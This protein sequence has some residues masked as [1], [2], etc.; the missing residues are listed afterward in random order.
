M[1]ALVFRGPWDIDVEDRP[2]PEPAPGEVLVE[3]VATGICGSDLHGYTGENGRRF[4]GQVMGHETVGRVAAI[5]AANGSGGSTGLAV[6]GLVTVEPVL[7]CGS[8]AACRSGQDHRCAQRRIIGVDPAI[9]AAFADLM[10]VPAANAVP[11]PDGMPPEYGALV[12]PLAVGQHAIVRGHC[13]PDD[14]VLVIGGGPIGQA[15]A[16]AARRAGVAGLVVSEPSAGRR[17]LL[18]D[19]GLSTVD[20]TE[21]SVAEN[22]AD[23]LGA[24][25]SVVVDAVGSSRS[26]ADALAVGVEGGRVVLVGMQEP[27]LSLRAYAVSIEERT[28]IGSYCYPAKDFHDT[29]AWVATAPPELARLIEGRVGWAEASEAFRGLAKGENPASKVLVFPSLEQ[30]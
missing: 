17:A 10:V 25:P 18:S 8:C 1:R 30:S 27:D 19:I 13:G 5:G 22:V 11:L 15:C 23:V 14:T 16:L 12:E 26:M 2:D 29:A 3:V 4:P 9:S 24:A 28:V 21:G 6:G 20:P 7:A